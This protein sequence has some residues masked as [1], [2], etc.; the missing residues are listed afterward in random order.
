[1]I[2]YVR[3]NREK[4]VTKDDKKI[5]KIATDKPIVTVLIIIY[6][7]VPNFIATFAP[8]KLKG[9]EIS[10]MIGNKIKVSFK[11]RSL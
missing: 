4:L 7:L 3:K 10:I 2:P 8:K 5:P 9:P 6:S 11:L 1:M